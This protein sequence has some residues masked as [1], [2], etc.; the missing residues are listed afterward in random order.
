MVC[1]LCGVLFGLS[2]CPDC[3]RRFWMER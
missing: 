2:R 3:W 1:I